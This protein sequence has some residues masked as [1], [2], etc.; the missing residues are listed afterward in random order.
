MSRAEALRKNLREMAGVN[1]EQ[2]HQGYQHG[3]NAGADHELEEALKQRC[4]WTGEIE[5]YGRYDTGC[6]HG[7][8]CEE[9]GLKENGFTHCIYCGKQIRE[10]QP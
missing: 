3:F 7:F 6:G 4:I 10:V 9:D 8:A 5:A 1:S 2:Y